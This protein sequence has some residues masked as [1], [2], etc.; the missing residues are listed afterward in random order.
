[1]KIMGDNTEKDNNEM[2]KP[3]EIMKM[4]RLLHTKILIFSEIYL[5]FLEILMDVIQILRYII[6]FGNL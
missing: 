2:V 1:M 6:T 3:L 4:I 5:R